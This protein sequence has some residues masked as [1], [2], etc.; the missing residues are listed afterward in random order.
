[1]MRCILSIILLLTCT[2]STHGQSTSVHDQLVK[3]DQQL[4]VEKAKVNQLREKRDQAQSQ[5]TS[6]EKMLASELFDL[7]IQQINLV[8]QKQELVNALSLE[9]H[10]ADEL[11]AQRKQVQLTLT[12]QAQQ[13]DIDLRELPGMSAMRDQIQ[14]SLKNKGQWDAGQ[15]KVLLELLVQTQQHASTIHLNQVSIPTADGTVEEVELLSIGHVAF[16]YSAPNRSAVGYALAA[17]E[18]ASGFRW[19]EE[20]SP[21]ITT[22]L[23]ASFAQIPMTSSLVE[24]PLDITQRIRSENLH[25]ALTL[26]DRIKSG[27]LIMIP[28]FALTALALL[29]ITERF[30]TLYIQNG[31]GTAQASSIIRATLYGQIDEARDKASNAQT[32]VARTLHACLSRHEVG[33]HAMEDAIQE[34]LLHEMPKLQRFL[35]GIAILAA[36][37][38][39]LGLLGTVT[40]IIRTFGVIQSFGNANPSLM[41]GGIS[42]ALITTAAGLIIAIP[43]LLAHSLLKGRVQTILSDAEKHAATLLNTLTYTMNETAKGSGK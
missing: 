8:K 22:A 40:G 21:A 36:V 31:K 11:A 34:Q 10:H 41:A 35:G 33:S 26:E 15:V 5:L 24:I 4:A 3:L 32:A 1:M 23:Q 2:M 18:D 16:A 6:D 28:M 25:Q 19:S 20:L 37:A 17:P 39:L 38:P 43:L 9:Q 30:F 7:Q 12:Q 29:M 42:E 14:N 27:G 13:L